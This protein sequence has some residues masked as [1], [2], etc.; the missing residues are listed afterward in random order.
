MKPA[1][2]LTLALLA[3]SSALHG[4]QPGPGG[5]SQA[6]TTDEDVLKAARFAVSAYDSKLSLRHVTTAEQQVV[7]GITG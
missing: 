4:R 3:F 1:T 6:A 2:L 7:A 5:F